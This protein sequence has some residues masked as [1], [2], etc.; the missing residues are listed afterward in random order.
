MKSSS[1]FAEDSRS[2][3]FWI[4]IGLSS[5]LTLV[6][7]V[8]GV[9]ITQPVVCL[10]S[11]GTLSLGSAL[12]GAFI[13]AAVGFAQHAWIKKM[14]IRSPLW[15]WATVTAWTAGIWLVNFYS[16]L[17]RCFRSTNAPVM[18]KLPWV[19]D[20][21][22]AL[23]VL[24]GRVDQ[25]ISGEAM[26]AEISSITLY[27][28]LTLVVGILMGSLQGLAQWLA[29]RK[30]VP[31]AM[32]LLPV[33]LLAWCIAVTGGLLIGNQRGWALPGLFWG[34]I[35]PPAFTGLTLFQL[36][37]KTNRWISSGF[38]PVDRQTD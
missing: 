31:N 6:G 15:G 37:K 28:F 11:A 30:A 26:H 38:T 22:R 4:W 20:I 17:L 3:F 32:Q 5:L 7:S 1:N 36:R 2:H 8:A 21:Y 9:L 19:E 13:G 35:V 29:L 34:L 12:L 33:N 10:N 24:G 27:L 25:L 23:Y 18:F 14:G 16:P